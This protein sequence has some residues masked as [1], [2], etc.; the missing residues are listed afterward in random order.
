MSCYKRKESISGD[1]IQTIP[2]ASLCNH[3]TIICFP[4]GP[5]PVS[6]L[7]RLQWERTIW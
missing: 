6:P 4:V 7:G 1:S 2:G 3:R 5:V